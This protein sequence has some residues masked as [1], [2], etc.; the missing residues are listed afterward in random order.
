M[1]AHFEKL[2]QRNLN[3]TTFKEC[4]GIK[5]CE[6]LTLNLPRSHIA[7]YLRMTWSCQAFPKHRAPHFSHRTW[8]FHGVGLGVQSVALDDPLSC[9]SVNNKKHS[10]AI[11]LSLLQISLSFCSP[12]FAHGPYHT[13]KEQMSLQHTSYSI[14]STKSFPGW[15]NYVHHETLIK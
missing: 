2:K 15:C 8:F 3:G 6:R 12:Y 5:P 4:N 10:I 11:S 14:Q 9:W 13:Y 7:L 1:K